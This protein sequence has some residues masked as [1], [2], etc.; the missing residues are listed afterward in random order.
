MAAAREVVEQLLRTADIEIDGPDPWDIKV[1]DER[2][3]ARV[4][5]G[6]TL[7]FGEAYMDGWWDCE[8]LDEMCSRAISARLDERFTYSPRNLLAFAISLLTNRQSR[9][10]ARQVGQ[11]HYDL[12][13][14]FFRAMLDPWMQYSSAFFL[15]GD[16]LATAQRRKLE[17]VCQ[18]LDLHPGMRLLDVGCGWGGLAKYAAQN[19]GCSVTGLTISREQQQFAAS[20]CDGLEVEIQLRDYRQ[21]RGRFDCAV[22]VGMVEHV[23]FKNYRTYLR[24][25]ADSLGKDGLFL[26]QGICNPIS[27]WQLDPW[28]RRYIFP[29]SIL[30]SLARL[31]KAAEGLFLVQEVVNLGP[32]YDPTLLAWE[33]NFRRAWPRFAAHYDPRFRRMWRFYL[34]S[35]AGAFRARSLQ[36]YGILFAKPESK[37]QNQPLPAQPNESMAAR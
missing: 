25:I 6:G 33:E 34:L 1:Y 3:F 35:C 2:F 8:A 21:I 9:R 7:G 16:D 4:L 14:D 18:R 37:T 5:A 20:W 29:N 10:R 17:M 19:Y 32:H 28:I 11:V 13:N 30:P 15:E 31:T 24:A 36:V 12:G 22:S 27:G 23:G 26:C